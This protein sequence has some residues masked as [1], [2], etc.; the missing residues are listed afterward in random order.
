[1][2]F[3]EKINS[4]ASFTV[5]SDAKKKKEKEKIAAMYRSKTKISKLNILYFL[6]GNRISVKLRSKLVQ[7][8]I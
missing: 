8:N 1:M 3:F 7:I 2:E 4:Y 6:F 5:L